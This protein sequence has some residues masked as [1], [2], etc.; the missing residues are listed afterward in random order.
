MK[1]IRR[2][3][4]EWRGKCDQVSCIAL[5]KCRFGSVRDIQN[6]RWKRNLR[7]TRRRFSVF[8]AAGVKIRLCCCSAAHSLK[9]PSRYQLRVITGTIYH[10]C[11]RSNLDSTSIFCSVPPLSLLIS[12]ADSPDR[13]FTKLLKTWGWYW[14][15]GND[16]QRWFE[17]FWGFNRRTLIH[18]I[19]K[20]R[21][22]IVDNFY[23]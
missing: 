6:G 18:K 22:A 11:A 1:R 17:F 14:D 13:F 5:Q 3:P 16:Y 20:P 12:T 21:F 10:S 9:F 19:S 8:I 4:G 7:S 23:R 15:Q 2:C